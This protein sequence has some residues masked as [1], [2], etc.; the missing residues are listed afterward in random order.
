MLRNH[1]SPTTAGGVIILFLV[2]YGDRPD[3][4][5]PT[6][7]A[8]PPPA[9]YHRVTDTAGSFAGWL[10][11]LPLKKD[12]TV[13]LYD[14]TPKYNQN[15]QFAVLNVT[16]GRED[17]QQC[18]DAVM[19]LRA[20]YLR[21]R[22]KPAAIEFITEQGTRLNYREW[23]NG[24]RVRLAA[25]RLV[26][27]AHSGQDLFC[28]TRACFDDY[29]R[30]VFLY[31]GTRSL[32]RQ[33]LSR[34]FGAMR[35]G[36]VLIRGGSPGHAML[37]MDMAED[38]AGHRV[39]LLAQSYMPAQDIHIVRNPGDGA[40]SPWYRLQEGDGMIETPEWTFKTSQLRT[41]GP[42]H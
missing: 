38:A 15:A 40:L 8:I 3:N 29:L 23:E 39:Y 36:D 21:D 13:Y 17:L 42:E 18:A 31:C 20:E 34:P 35:P 19:R 11:T 30:T 12:R 5:Y 6:I 16:V 1:R 26:T 33:L 24:G 7:G 4:P 2:V 32:E 28:N 25:G 22:Q 37:V 10:R 14:G 27:Y 9:G 41:W